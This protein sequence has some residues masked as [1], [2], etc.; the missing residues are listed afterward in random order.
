MFSCTEESQYLE[1]EGN[2]S[3]REEDPIHRDLMAHRD[4]EMEDLTS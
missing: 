1:E 3:R 4:G 2:E